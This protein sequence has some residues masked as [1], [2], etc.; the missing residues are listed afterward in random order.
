MIKLRANWCFSCKVKKSS[1]GVRRTSNR[2]SPFVCVNNPPLEAPCHMLLIISSEFRNLE[3]FLGQPHPKKL[4]K[5]CFLGFLNPNVSPSLLPLSVTARREKGKL[6][7][8]LD[9]GEVQHPAATVTM[10]SA[11]DRIARKRRRARFKVKP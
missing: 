2:E 10:G 5:F 7:L 3:F 9:S 4:A 6:F 11:S 8:R 1:R